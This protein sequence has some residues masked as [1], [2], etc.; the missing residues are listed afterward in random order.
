MSLD[1]FVTTLKYGASI[2]DVQILLSGVFGFFI[3]NF[4]IICRFGGI[5]FIS[6]VL[7]KVGLYSDVVQT[8]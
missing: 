3:Y 8:Y 1:S 7:R 4:E 2:G 6:K 5:M